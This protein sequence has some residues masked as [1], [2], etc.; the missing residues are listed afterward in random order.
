MGNQTKKVP[1]ENS[2]IRINI[3]LSHHSATEVVISMDIEHGQF[4]IGKGA[5]VF[6]SCCGALDYGSNTTKD[7]L[8]NMFALM[9]ESMKKDE[10]AQGI[11]TTIKGKMD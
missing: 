10:K 9:P 2:F 6:N 3:L 4:I 5:F 7:F 8:E 1:K 11:I